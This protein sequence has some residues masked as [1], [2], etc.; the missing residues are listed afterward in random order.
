MNKSEIEKWLK[1]YKI[2]NYTINSDLTVD[3]KGNVN[4]SS[5]PLKAIPFQFGKVDGDFY[6]G[7]NELTSLEHCPM[8]ISGNFNCSWNKLTSFEHCPKT[9][10]GYFYCYNNPFVANQKNVASWIRAI[11]IHKNVYTHI[12]KDQITS[13]LTQLQKMMWEV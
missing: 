9:V 13:D 11:G 5:N 10:G 12:P 1:K 3:V 4:I 8:I 6:C 2:D 7:N